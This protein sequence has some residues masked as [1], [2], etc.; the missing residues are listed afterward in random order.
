MYVN[1]K[2]M[3]QDAR[4]N[5]YCV[6]GVDCWGLDSA[7]MIVDKAVEKRTPIIVLVNT[8][9]PPTDMR[10][11]EL[12]T[13]TVKE[14]AARTD[15]PIAVQLDHG[16]SYEEAAMAIHAG[17]SAVMLDASAFPFE[18]NVAKVKEVVRMAHACGVTVE[19]ELGHV[20]KGADWDEDDESHLTEVDEAAEFIRLTDVDSLAV[21]IGT[22]H[23]VY[24]GTPHLDY[25]RLA[26]I[27]AKTDLPLVLHGGSGTG[28][29]A[30][31]KAV[32]LG[33][34]KLN[35]MT[36]VLTAYRNGFDASLRFPADGMEPAGCRVLDE[37]LTTLSAPMK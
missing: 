9:V 30:L 28:L 3:L 6:L 37:Y 5:H 14:L 31:R 1:T 34:S 26:A 13:M 18:E 20:G 22:I 36:D 23:G 15:V 19:A 12:V 16:L 17:F 25:E 32:D 11:M 29:P 10:E 2:K 8:K 35:V 7:R 33:I 4:A 21:S 24:R 27:A